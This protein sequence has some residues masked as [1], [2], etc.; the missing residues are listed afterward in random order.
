MEVVNSTRFS[1]IEENIDMDV[2]CSAGAVFFNSRE[3]TFDDLYE[4]ADKIMYEAKESGRDRT[5]IGKI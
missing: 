5:N 2:H 1:Y 3:L 4:A